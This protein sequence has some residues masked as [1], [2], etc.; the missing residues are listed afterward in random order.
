[1][2]GHVYV[3][4]YFRRQWKY[5]SLPYAPVCHEG[6]DSA[7]ELKAKAM[8]EAEVIDPTN[9]L[10][11]DLK[12]LCFKNNVPLGWATSVGDNKK[13]AH[14]PVY[15]QDRSRKTHYLTAK[16]AR[17]LFKKLRPISAQ[18]ELIARILLF[19]NGSMEQSG[20]Y[21]TLESLLRIKKDDVLQEEVA[22][23]KNVCLQ[24]VVPGKGTPA[25]VVH[26]LPK[27][28]LKRVLLLVRQK[29]TSPFLFSNSNGRPLQAK[30]VTDDIKA[31][32]KEAGLGSNI[33]S[34]SLRPTFNVK[35]SKKIAKRNELRDVPSDFLR[36]VS[37]E[38]Y[39]AACVLVLNEHGKKRR[40]PTYRSIDVINAILYCLSAGKTLKK[41]PASY[42]PA[43]AV[44]S[45]YRRWKRSGIFR[46]LMKALFAHRGMNS[47]QI[48]KFCHFPL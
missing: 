21:I 4:V 17:L 25:Y 33:F 37:E 30:Q 47:T 15:I 39:N 13:S 5:L 26:Y 6:A 22:G 1:M 3:R 9:L 10:L 23:V 16:E 46:K 2:D 42:P 14:T 32:G 19:L 18:S 20:S 31:A 41:L 48:A 8:A 44:E 45:Q 38:E 11:A 43:S 28:L 7:D 36:P 12:K 27:A 29:P 24:L 35:R 34:L 40:T